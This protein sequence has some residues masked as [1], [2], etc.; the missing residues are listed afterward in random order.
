M[1]QNTRINA[2]VNSTSWLQ[3]KPLKIHE[4]TRR[5]VDCTIVERSAAANCPVLQ[6]QSNELGSSILDGGVHTTAQ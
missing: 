4:D 6:D 1:S 3:D 5:A 2:L